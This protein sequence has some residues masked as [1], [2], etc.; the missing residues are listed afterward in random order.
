MFTLDYEINTSVGS[1]NHFDGVDM[2]CAGVSSGRAPASSGAVA[3]LGGVREPGSCCLTDGELK[4]RQKQDF[5]ATHGNP[6]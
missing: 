4:E 3:L 5:S 2:A 1:F 6:R